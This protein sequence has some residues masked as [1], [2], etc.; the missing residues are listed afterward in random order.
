MV[1]KPKRRRIAKP[2]LTSRSF[3]IKTEKD[4]P[5]GVKGPKGFPCRTWAKNLV[6]IFYERWGSLASR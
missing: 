3:R 1:E 5:K 2:E 6:A 4:L